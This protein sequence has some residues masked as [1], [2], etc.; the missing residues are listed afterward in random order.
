MLGVDPERLE[1]YNLSA[2]QGPGGQRSVPNLPKKS[3]GVGP[4]P[5]WFALRKKKESAQAEKQ[6]A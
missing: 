6:P 2:A 1:F 4:S 5:I 3:L